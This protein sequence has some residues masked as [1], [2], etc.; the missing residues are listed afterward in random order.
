MCICTFLICY[1]ISFKKI[2]WFNHKN[3]C[4]FLILYSRLIIYLVRN[5]LGLQKPKGT[6]DLNL[7]ASFTSCALTMCMCA[8]LNNSNS[9]TF[10]FWIITGVRSWISSKVTLGFSAEESIMCKPSGG[11][12][13]RDC[14]QEHTCCFFH[15][16]TEL[17][18]LNLSH[19]VQCSFTV[20]LSDA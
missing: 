12:S 20:I 1:C 3:A 18:T 5:V 6:L 16:L 13:S 19:S 2:I 11:T 8:S 15:C 7:T 9:N 14:E 10:L 4:I 17:C